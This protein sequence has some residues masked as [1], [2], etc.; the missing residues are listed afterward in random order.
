MQES[1]TLNYQYILINC[2]FVY[3]N[4]KSRV[5]HNY[6]I[7]TYGHANVIPCFSVDCLY[8]LSCCFFINQSRSSITMSELLRVS[9]AFLNPGFKKKTVCSTQGAVCLFICITELLCKCILYV[10]NNCLNPKKINTLAAVLLCTAEIILIVGV[11]ICRSTG[12]TADWALSLTLENTSLTADKWN[13]SQ[14]LKVWLG[15]RKFPG[16]TREVSCSIPTFEN[17]WFQ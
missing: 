9:S 11:W 6:N 2:I 12:I 17:G 3:I 15:H 4:C 16:F 10:T 5:L 1:L 8:F 13:K 7:D 14:R